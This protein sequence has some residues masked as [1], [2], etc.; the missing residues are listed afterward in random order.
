M[1]LNKDIRRSLASCLA[2]VL[3]VGL[4]A[5]IGMWPQAAHASVT[6]LIA[7][8]GFE[9]GLDG[10]NTGG[11][12]KFTVTDVTYRSGSYGLQIDGPQNWNGVKYTVAGLLPNTDYTL[13]F[14]SKGEG[15]AA[16]KVLTPG[17]ATIVEGYTGT[18]ADWT[19]YSLNFN[20]GASSSVILY[21]SDANAAAYYDDFVLERV[22]PNL[23]ANGGFENG[24]DGWNA[25]GNAKFS[26]SAAEFRS[27]AHS[28]QVDSPQ[29][30]NGIKYTVD[31]RPNT[32]YT[33]KFY[34]KGGGGAA[35]KVLAADEA[36]ITENYTSAQA[37]W[38]Q[39]AVNFNSGTNE[40]IILYISDA[41]QTAYYDDF[42][43][44]DPVPPA[45]KPVASNVTITGVAKV[46][47]ALSGAFTYTHPDHIAQGYSIYKWLQAD[48]EDGTYAAI[49]AANQPTF[50][51]TITQEGKYVK[52]EV[53]P[54]DS[55]GLAGLPVTSSAVGP[56]AAASDTEQALY[57]L[58]VLIGQAESELNAS[59]V[60]AA[61]GQYPQNAWDSVE[62][63]IA[64]AQASAS[65][66]AATV[67]SVTAASAAL[68][69]AMSAFDDAR[70]KM[71]SPLA[72]F[73]TKDG[74]KLM[75]GAE[76][77]RF[78]SYNYPGALFNEDEGEGLVPTAFEQEDAIRTIAQSGGKV[79]RTYSLTVRDKEDAPDAIRH[80]DGP[81]II[82]EEAFVSLDKLLQLANQHQV[83]VIIPFIDNWD[84]PPGGIT[85]FAHF[86]GKVRMEFYTDPQLIQD[87]KQVLDQ[88]MNR[89]NSFTGVRYKDDPAILAW[90]TGNE[91]MVAPEWM[92]EIAAY[93]KSINPNQ[94]LI[95]GNQMELPHFYRNISD[96]ALADPNIDIVK[97]HYYSGNY[98]AQV[99]ADKAKATAHNKPFIVGE[100]GF[101]PTADITA[102]ID[103]VI[104]NGTSGAMIWSLRPHSYNGG[105][106]RHEE[107][108]VDGILYR[109][110]HWPGFP[111]GDY[112][113]ATSIVHLIREKAY[114]I[115]GLAVPALPVP[116]P[117][118]ELIATDS[119][120]ELRFRGSTGA[121]FYTVE[122]AQQPAGP[123]TVIGENVMD[124]V[125]PG[126]VIFSDTTAISGTVYYYRVKGSNNSGETPYSN[127]IG[128]IT[129]KFVLTDELEDDSK[130]YYATDSS[131]VY[132]VPSAIRS[133]A[134]NASVHDEA[135][136]DYV[137]ELS[138]DGIH[139]T[140]VTPEKSGSAYS[141]PTVLV[142]NANQL[143]IIYPGGSKDNGELTHVTI[144]YTG[145]GQALLPVKPLV[146]SGVLT[147]EMED[148][149]KVFNVGNVTLEQGA[150]T[151]SS[152]Y[153]AIGKMQAAVG[154]GTIAFPRTPAANIVED[155][156]L[157]GGESLL[158]AQAYTADAAGG[159]IEL[160]L[161]TAVKKTG[162]YS[163]RATYDMGSANYVGLAKTFTQADRSAYDTLQLWVKPDGNSRDLVVRLVTTDDQ[164]WLRGLSIT[165]TAGKTINLPIASFVTTG[166]VD[167]LDLS[168]LKQFELIVGKG[169]G[170]STGTLH[171]DDVRFVQ[172]QV[173]DSFDHYT[174][175]AA[176]AARYGTRN[177]SGGPVTGSLS[178]EFKADGTHAMKLEYDLAGPGYA[179]LITQ[180]PNVDWSAYDTV[181]MWV[182]PG[183]SSVK[184]TIQVKMG[185]TQVMESTVILTGG[186]EG[187]ILEIPFADF[188]YPSWY[189]GTGTLNPS[190]IVEFNIYFGQEGSS[191]SGSIYMDQIRLV[192]KAGS[193]P[194]DSVGS[195]G[196]WPAHAAAAVQAESVLDGSRIVRSGSGEAYMMYRSLAD[197][198]AFKLETYHAEQ[199]EEEADH[200]AFFGS[201]DGETFTALDAEIRYLGGM[202]HKT[203]YELEN[204]P[205]GIRLLK[206][207]LPA[208]ATDPIDPTD[209]TD[210]T[211][212]A[213]TNPG[214][215]TIGDGQITKTVTPNA[216]G[217][218]TVVLQASEIE[219]ALAKQKGSS[220]TINVKPAAGTKAVK[221][222]VPAQRLASN[223]AVKTVKFDTG[224]A[225]IT[226]NQRLIEAAAS[227]SAA[228]TIELSVAEVET[229][230]L[231]DGVQ[232]QL[233]GSKVYDFNLNINGNKISDFRGNEVLVSIP[234]ML[235]AGDNPKK[236]IVYYVNDNGSLEV[237]K[238][239]KYN[240][241]TGVVEFKAK[242]FSMYSPAHVDRKFIDLG[243]T[244][245]AQESI[246]A[247][248]ARDMVTGIAEGVFDPSGAVTRAAFVQ[249]LMNA[250][251]LADTDAAVAFSDVEADAWY[252][253][254]VSSA[255][256]LGIVQ[257]MSDGEFHPEARI[258]RQDMAVMLHRA[259]KLL[260]LS[261]SDQSSGINFKDADA[262]GSYAID[263]VR[264]LQRAGIVRG[265]ADGRFAPGG[266]AT[267]AEA[268]VMIYRVYE[269]QE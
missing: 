192:D 185:N 100:F 3:L 79:F 259:V 155:G 220:F 187:S 132:R 235:N 153:P 150:P 98:A 260:E 227:G 48:T 6:N 13:S 27:G 113:D 196:N 149:T 26:D 90:E 178:S 117:A 229:S 41:G 131:V 32:D 193:D 28:L 146:A 46:A 54:V 148:Y 202:Y 38:F 246:E 142:P 52:L 75:D 35:Y 176:F 188:D 162:D 240:P 92:S 170:P 147:D 4:L 130:Q 213:P 72:N 105:F 56:V 224:I 123:W 64:D 7:N 175:P 194:T 242:H 53:T 139:F 83:R 212:P 258:T 249:M 211:D 226:I 106:I 67:D 59:S 207:V 44:G 73:I 51:P 78:I 33:L 37:D 217:Q 63:A 99:E 206:V 214:T 167:H 30:W 70:I 184:L 62:Q 124:D 5:P 112:Q 42:Y 209:P 108:A 210:P 119:I 96:A 31:V 257:G 21:V 126:D 143:R 251:D 161:D 23:I 174:E 87:F 84:W 24:L 101:K 136:G 137:F 239:G 190:E 16:Y 243:R 14:Y 237:V 57:A 156:E 154:S 122:R 107:Y 17:E 15:G 102:M 55:K 172:T 265:M 65:D 261:L 36:T 245:W 157:Y 58:Q 230:S 43:I 125:E 19:R 225:A 179:G 85:D 198:N 247:L 152:A 118:P 241:T 71:G 97:S 252:R 182:K 134:V 201:A 159:E 173:I 203:N 151:S 22:L 82:N 164:V 253:D 20:S 195:V 233:G 180:L 248:A 199:P 218:A 254:A 110:Y 68:A 256:K 221:I 114:A 50:V 264:S 39:Y 94:L 69:A 133:F 269:Q 186:A 2:F 145:N 138:A 18:N 191:T 205:A 93:Y 127:L 80:I 60:G 244:T 165:G 88:V 9:S 81:G 267:R 250:L 47:Q 158:A 144:E 268:A 181:S 141:V 266:N 95:S 255:Q 216:N 222:T 66:A 115:Q 129:A 263:A 169:T 29:D 140:A 204:L 74:T 34:G 215:G 228:A 40:T 91:L 219:E 168:H 223:D 76:E 236:V 116:A 208:G 86:R 103:K 189:G 77:L 183:T 45:Q 128:P 171:L 232:A 104:E 11:N 234:Y 231:P 12:S 109:S 8:G 166:D 89:V 61:Y 111:S 197:M 163:V 177:N 135:H 49:P 10:W 238:N 120:T 200:Y 25:G 160:A 262:I 1:R 121:K